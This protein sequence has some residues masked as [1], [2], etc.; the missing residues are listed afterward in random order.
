MQSFFAS[1]KYSDILIYFRSEFFPLNFCDES[2]LKHYFPTRL[3]AEHM[4][5]NTSVHV[6]KMCVW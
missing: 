1:P 5:V 3:L 6:G 4:P 2:T